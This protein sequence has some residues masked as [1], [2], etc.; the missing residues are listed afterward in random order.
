MIESPLINQIVAEARGKPCKKPSLR[1]SRH[2]LGPFP[3]TLSN[4]FASSA[5][6][7]S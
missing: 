6:R 4:G 3:K 1:F 7:K 5:V 2:G